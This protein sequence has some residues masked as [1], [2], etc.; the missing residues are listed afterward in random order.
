MTIEGGEEHNNMMTDAEAH[1]D[2][3]PKIWDELK[4]TGASKDVAAAAAA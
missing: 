3:M 2:V 4:K 1:L